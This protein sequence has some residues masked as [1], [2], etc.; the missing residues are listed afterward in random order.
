MIKLKDYQLEAIEELTIKINKLFTVTGR[1]KTC[2]FKSPTGSGKTVIVA[3]VIEN[4]ISTNS[5]SEICF[6]WVSIGKGELHIQSKK[7]LD[8]IFDGFPNCT[9]LEQDFLGNRTEIEKNEVV[10]INWEKIRNKDKQTGTWKNKVMVTGENKNFIEIIEETRKKR[11]IILIIDESHY[12]SEAERAI[13]LRQIINADVTLEMS[14]TLKNL[15]KP[16]DY[17]RGLIEIQIVDSSQVIQEGMIKKNTIINF[18]IDKLPTND[19]DSQDIILNSAYNKREDLK[20]LFELT[21]SKVNPLCLIQLPNSDAGETKKR[22]VLDFLKSKGAT[23]ENRK[24]ALWLSNEKSEFLD[25]ISNPENEV[26]FLLFKQ[27]I[28]T[29]WDCPGHLS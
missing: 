6:L 21:G 23:L 16:E 14:A 18:E 26:E 4:V 11:K 15:F 13:E 28:D 2:Y 12:A 27:A 29:G 3:K 8:Y 7:T 22:S 1:D 19:L 5:D 10:V 25:E 17:A 24:V 20:E 9:L